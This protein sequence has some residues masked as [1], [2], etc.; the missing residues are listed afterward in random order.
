VTAGA[1]EH[2]RPLPSPAGLDADWY[3]HCARGE[4]RFQRC[5]ACGRWRHPPR[6]LCAACGSEAW[7]WARATGRGEVFSW[8]VTH[9]PLHPAFADAL[10]YVIVVIEMEEGVRVVAGAR[11]IER[12]DL[13]LGLPVEVEI[14]RVSETVGLL[15]ARPSTV[16]GG[17]STSAGPGRAK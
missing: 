2:P 7:E 6:L 17:G 3:A 11:D 5:G 4:L 10:P 12:V 1:S 8:T 13:D 14:D 15:Y 9:Q 16:P